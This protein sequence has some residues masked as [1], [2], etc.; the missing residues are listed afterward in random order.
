MTVS[1]YLCS[2]KAHHYTRYLKVSHPSP[3][4]N[5]AQQ[6]QTP[7]SGQESPAQESTCEQTPAAA[8]S[9]EVVT[10]PPSADRQQAST[11]MDPMGPNDAASATTQA[12]T[13][14]M[15]PIPTMVAGPNQVEGQIVRNKPK[16]LTAYTVTSRTFS[17]PVVPRD[18]KGSPI[19]PFSV[20]SLTVVDLG[21]ICMREHF[22]TERYIFPVGYEVTRCV[23]FAI[24]SLFTNG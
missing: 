8:C 24:R 16:R 18:E 5:S 17:I 14:I 7:P 3:M 12:F 4:S 21:Q 11:N 15:R 13:P 22:H 1:S 9:S 19:L 10:A 6:A 23:V 2:S 20:E